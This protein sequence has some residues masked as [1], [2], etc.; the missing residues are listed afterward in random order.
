MRNSHQI[1][2]YQVHYQKLCECSEKFVFFMY[3]NY[4]L[5]TGDRWNLFDYESTNLFL[6][7]TNDVHILNKSIYN[8]VRLFY[9]AISEDSYVFSFPYIS[10][11]LGNVLLS[12]AQI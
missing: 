4:F 10:W 6:W 9:F 5:R 7:H 3:L 12:G 2:R 1:K 8:W 11:S